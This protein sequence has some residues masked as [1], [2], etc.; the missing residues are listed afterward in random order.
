MNSSK[1][2]RAAGRSG[3]RCLSARRPALLRP[4]RIGLAAGWP[5]EE[6]LS[7]LR[8]EQARSLK[9]MSQFGELNWCGGAEE[10]V[11]AGVEKGEVALKG[12]GGGAGE[13][14]LLGRSAQLPFDISP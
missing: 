1:P 3:S 10:I 4:P 8:L 6:L 9:K 12:G 2:H 5:P 11:P 13:P 14:P 7:S